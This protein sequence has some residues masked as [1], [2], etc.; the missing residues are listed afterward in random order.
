MRRRFPPY[1]SRSRESDRNSADRASGGAGWSEDN[2]ARASPRPLLVTPRELEQALRDCLSYQAVD[3]PAAADPAGSAVRRG[4][5][6][7]RRRLAAAAACLT[8]VTAVATAA[9]SQL[10]PPPGRYLGPVVM[11]ESTPDHVPGDEPSDPTGP[12]GQ[13][14]ASAL[15][16]I[17]ASQ[18]PVDVVVA[19]ELRAATGER[20]DLSSIGI[21]QRAHRAPGGWL[22]VA[23]RPSGKPTLWFV[24]LAGAPRAVLSGVDAV[25]VAPGGERVAW[26]DGNQ[27]SFATVVGG[28]LAGSGQTAAPAG[29]RP[30]GFVGAGVL[31]ARDGA[32]GRRP[33]YDVWW[34][35]RGSYTPVWTDSISAVYG[36]MADGRV[37][38][39]KA[40]VVAG[41]PPCLALVDAARGLAVA[42]TA[43][44]VAFSPEASGTV[45]PDGRWLVVDAAAGASPTPAAGPIP[46]STPGGHV[47]VLV[48]LDTAFGERPAV[49]ELGPRLGTECVWTDPQTLVY[50]DSEGGLVRVH[51][52]RAGNDSDDVVE[53]LVV[54]GA[55]PRDR[56]VLVTPP[57]G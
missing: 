13:L 9:V 49:T 48:D 30:V 36:S 11:G 51:A 56:I 5:R 25:V 55:G 54:P 2:L 14:T 53:R 44:T 37:L 3:A 29:T 47:T 24:P 20:V 27:A 4:R 38:V 46:G 18:P 26:R 45:S 35:D 8:L 43:C 16:T 15:A 22:V 28:R 31:M 17:E 41:Q 32:G 33:G 1:R 34:P 7:R 50:A 21:V 42:K 39:G 6:I 57:R 52:N 40:T 10:R 12:P 23:A 19:R